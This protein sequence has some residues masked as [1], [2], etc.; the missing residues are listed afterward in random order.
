VEQEGVNRRDA[1]QWIIA[2]TG[3]LTAGRWAG[4]HPV[5]G[6]GSDDGRLQ[7]RVRRP[8][9]AVGPGLRRLGLGGS[10]DGLLYLPAKYRAETAAPLALLLHGAG[11]E[12][13]VMVDPMKNLAEESGLVLLAPD[14]R[15][16]TWDATRGEYG[17]DI[18]FID[19]ALTWAFE[20]I[21]VDPAR[22]TVAGFSDGA[23]YA[24]SIGLINGDLFH[25]IA[26]FSPGFVV[27]GKPTGHPKIFI[28]HGTEDRILPIDRASR[29]IVPDLRAQGYAV[30]YHEFPGPHMMKP[31]LLRVAAAWLAAN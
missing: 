2:G 6:G 1:L 30:E 26:A 25:R 10:R 12:A 23:S 20:R 9:Q 4:P 27:P 18:R 29:R 8:R 24:L 7:A 22:V 3:A 5:S 17:P 14:S 31:A 11:Q 16:V 19:L 15:D 28:T 13:A 21:R